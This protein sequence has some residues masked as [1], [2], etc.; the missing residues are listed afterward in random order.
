MHSAPTVLIVDDEAVMAMLL[1]RKLKSRGFT[2]CGAVST[3]EEAV[4][5]AT[6]ENPDFILMDIRLIGTFDGIE[7]ASEISSKMKCHIIFMTGY[8]NGE[9]RRRA[10]ELKPLAYLVKP[11]DMAELLQILKQASP[12][13]L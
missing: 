11:F 5:I 10:M 6:R 8:S 1:E 3:K 9:V 13:T 4:D 2:V 7:A 12:K